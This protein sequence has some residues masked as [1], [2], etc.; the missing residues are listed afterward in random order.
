MPLKWVELE[1]R[2]RE[3][4][5][6]SNPNTPEWIGNTLK[7][8]KDMSNDLIGEALDLESKTKLVEVIGTKTTGYEITSG[9]PYLGEFLRSINN[10]LTEWSGFD[11][12]SRKMLP[13]DEVEMK[14]FMDS[15]VNATEY[16]L[17]RIDDVSE[18]L[19]GSRCSW[20][21]DRIP[22][23][24]PRAAVN[25]M[26]ACFHR[27]KLLLTTLENGFEK[28]EGKCQAVKNSNG[29]LWDACRLWDEITERLNDGDFYMQQDYGELKGYVLGN[30]MQFRVGSSHGHLTTMDL[31]KGT[32]NYY[33]DDDLV[34]RNMARLLN[35][36]GLNCQEV[37]LGVSCTGL[38]EGNVDKAAEILSLPTSMD[39][40]I[41]DYKD[42]ELQE[43]IDKKRHEY[44]V[45]AQ[46]LANK[47]MGNAE[48][49]PYNPNLD[50][51]ENLDNAGIKYNKCEFEKFDNYSSIP[52]SKSIP[53]FK[54]NVWREPS[55]NAKF[56]LRDERISSNYIDMDR[57]DEI[58]G[59]EIF[60]RTGCSNDFTC[61][62]NP[63]GTF[64]V[65][66]ALNQLYKTLPRPLFNKDCLDELGPKAAN[67][68]YNSDFEELNKILRTLKLPE[69]TV[70]G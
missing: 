63:E 13:N 31:D 4:A 19:T 43:C 9:V 33:D 29:K 7:L 48:E 66:V 20:L 57:M 39:I 67:A 45:V 69:I 11:E 8:Y 10:A 41:R 65:F 46:W 22:N 58:I 27:A 35:L 21:V 24:T 47:A 70:H 44:Y 51:G 16:N 17:R 59:E 6:E 40:R 18:K 54:V 23:Y 32:L 38:T 55:P 50:L 49:L 3:L 64:R 5:S 28:Q 56:N 52:G 53:Q 60:K 68:V 62:D 61:P 30:T 42:K 26:T 34:N 15:F 36:I 12:G 1:G 2:G 37:H 25:D 14:I